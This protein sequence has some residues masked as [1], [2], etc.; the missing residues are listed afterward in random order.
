MTAAERWAPPGE[1]LIWSSKPDPAFILLRR[2]GLLV[3]LLAAAGAALWLGG[4]WGG[5]AAAVALGGAALL[6]LWSS[7]VWAC[8]TY[9]LTDKHAVW[10]SGVIRRLIVQ[11]PLERV[12]NVAVYRSLPERLLGLGTVGL[13]TAGTDTFEL[14]WAMVPRP[15]DRVRE[16]NAAVRAVREHPAPPAAQGPAPAARAPANVPVIGL[17]GA[18]GAGKSEVARI[19]ERLG[20]VVIDSDVQARAALERP[21]VRETL[22]GWWGGGILG[23]D[24]RIDRRA[25]ASIVFADPGERRRLEE[26]VHPIIREARAEIV[27]RERAR[28]AR[29]E[30]HA[31]A[32]IIDAPL[33]YE[34]GVD[35]ECDAVIFVDAPRDVRLG[36]VMSARGWDDAELARREA[37]QMPPEEK[38]RRA[39]QV[40]PNTGSL[41]DLAA[42]TES[43]LH[44]IE[45]AL[46]LSAGVRPGVPQGA[47]GGG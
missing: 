15:H 46:G 22:T 37:A 11:T 9:A 20:C 41:E 38:R 8:Q 1:R 4:P 47:A 24:G 6:L 31:R 45:E 10:A 25:V 39:D 21:D 16:V 14:V 26:L 36:R 30:P 3:L 43:A 32:L 2:W 40:V 5:R 19:L 18:I 28:A 33:L 12:Q 7:L 13:A 35:R 29:G 27:Q 42:H 44:R 23:A 17:V 34:A